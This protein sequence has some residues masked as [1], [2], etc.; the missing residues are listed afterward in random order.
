MSSLTRQRPPRRRN[1][2]RLEGI[3]PILL[4][5]Q[6][7][8][9]FCRPLQ[10]SVANKRSNQSVCLSVCRYV[11]LSP[12]SAAVSHL[13]ES[14]QARLRGIQLCPHLEPGILAVDHGAQALE[15][16]P[17]GGVHSEEPGLGNETNAPDARLR[18]GNA[19][20]VRLRR[21]VSHSSSIRTYVGKKKKR[22]H[23]RVE[24]RSGEGCV[25][26]FKEKRESGDSS[27]AALR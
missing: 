17:G 26:Y 10:Q 11:F 22:E 5:E 25:E 4:R 1:T 7:A 8:T 6:G 13:H 27:V 19:F 14:K 23:E 9:L 15:G 20:H 12:L 2:R 21:L 16:E 3:Y 24:D 18:Q